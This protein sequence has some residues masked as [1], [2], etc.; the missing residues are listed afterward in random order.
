MLFLSLG[1]GD[2]VSLSYSHDLIPQFL[3]TF[4][5]TFASSL[6]MWAPDNMRAG[7]VNLG[8]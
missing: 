3:C 6:T 2:K 4:T 7:Q 8:L 5:P 1:S